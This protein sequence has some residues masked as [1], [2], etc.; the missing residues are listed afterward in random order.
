MK[1]TVVIGGVN[2]QREL[3]DGD[4]SL[5][6]IGHANCT[7]MTIIDGGAQLENVITVNGNITSEIDGEVGV[8]MTRREGAYP[9]YQ[10]P[11]E[12]T[13]SEQEQ[14]LVTSQ[15]SVLE[16]IVINPIPQNYGLI[17]WNGSTIRVS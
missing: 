4:A 13:P 10:G 9:D 11:T 6:V 3:I 14:T 17:T 8:F 7:L 12:I 5:E 2:V 16:N 1:D 15:K